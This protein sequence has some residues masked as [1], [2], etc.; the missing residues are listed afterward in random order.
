MPRKHKHVPGTAY[1]RNY[2]PENIELALAEVVNN[3]LSFGQAATRFGVPKT[4]LYSKYRGKFSDVLGRPSALS[5]IEERHITSAMITAA[6]YG[7]P[8]VKQDIKEFVQS[9]LNHKGV[10]IR[11]FKENLPGNDWL[12]TFLKRNRTLT[13]RN[14]ENI[15]RSRAEVDE[16]IINQYF[17]KIE[18]TLRDALP[19]NIINYDETN[20]TDDPGK[21]KVFVKKGNK[22]ARR[23]LDNS[24]SSTSVMFAATGGGELLPLYV[25]YQAKHLYPEWIERGP[26]GTIYNRSKNGWFDGPIF[27]D[28]FFKVALKYFRKKEG[29]KILIGDN[30]QSHLSEKVIRTC[31]EHNISFAFLPPNS[32]HICQPLDVAVFHPLKI[33]WRNVLTQWKKKFRGV[34]PKTEFPSLLNDLIEKARPNISNNIKSGFTACGLVPVNR[35]RVLQKVV[36]RRHP[37]GHDDD[38]LQ[39]TFDNIMRRNTATPGIPNK[40]R[41]KKIDVPPGKAICIEDLSNNPQPGPSNSKKDLPGPSNSRKELEIENN[42]DESDIEL[43]N[44]DMEIDS[45]DSSLC[46]DYETKTDLRLIPIENI[47]DI[48]VGGFVISEFIYNSKTKKETKKKFVSKII[49]IST[50]KRITVKCLRPYK[51]QT[52]KFIYPDVPDETVVSLNQLKCLLPFPEIRRG[53]HIFPNNIEL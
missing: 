19:E 48:S 46:P 20:F 31:E 2:D 52:N 25:V 51:G 28:W 33:I 17:D 44:D 37:I 45:E 3:R 9:Y 8:F 27:E 40:K 1:R 24:K 53:M 39:Q 29:K 32:T 18:E 12:E 38:A 13:Q 43:S 42:F 41:S 7:Y 15:K 21:Q 35:D 6:D 34:V 14:A 4:T 26:T 47:D 16:D 49:V 50:K 10:V 22:H 5:K 11:C 36:P 30:L 23:I